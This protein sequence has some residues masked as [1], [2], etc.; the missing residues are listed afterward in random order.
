[1]KRNSASLE[2]ANETVSESKYPYSIRFG[3]SGI[4]MKLKI[5]WIAEG[6]KVSFK[7]CDYIHQFSIP[8]SKL[9]EWV[10]IMM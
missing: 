5:G 1:M 9:S 7:H 4:I 3:P 8:Q 10:V 6:V 2:T